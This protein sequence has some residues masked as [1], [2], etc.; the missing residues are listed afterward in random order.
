MVVK[1]GMKPGNSYACNPF[2]AS[3][4]FGKIPCSGRA[5]VWI[6]SR[7]QTTINLYVDLYF[8]FGFIFSLICQ[9]VL[10]PI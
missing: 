8:L 10:H 2:W 9:E 1:V 7:D 5:R 3:D 6:R 4:S